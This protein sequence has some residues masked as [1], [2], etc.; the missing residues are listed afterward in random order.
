MAVPNRPRGRDSVDHDIDID[1]DIDGQRLPDEQPVELRRA[2]P[3]GF[4]VLR[5]PNP[6]IGFGGTGAHYR[7]GAHLTPVSEPMHLR[8]SFIT[9][10]KHWE[11]EYR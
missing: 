5:N 11:V 9:G 6:H 4:N 7:V 1:I 8:S 3:I 2:A 10:I